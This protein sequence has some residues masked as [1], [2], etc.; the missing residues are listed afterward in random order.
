M[1]EPGRQQSMELQELDMTEQLSIHT[2]YFLE[3]VYQFI[4]PS[5]VY[6]GFLFSIFLSAFV[7]S[8]LFDASHSTRYFI[9]VLI[10]FS[11][12]IIDA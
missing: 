4:I 9:V 2:Y 5:L 7:V 3:M 1:E 12:V 10:F 8:C 11:L 6:N